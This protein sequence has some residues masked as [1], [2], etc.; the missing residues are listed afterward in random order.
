MLRYRRVGELVG[1]DTSDASLL[2]PADRPLSY[3]RVEAEGSPAGSVALDRALLEA[4]SSEFRLR[5]PLAVERSRDRRRIDEALASLGAPSA[6]PVLDCRDTEAGQELDVAWLD[7]LQLEAVAQS[8]GWGFQRRPGGGAVGGLRIRPLYGLAAGGEQPSRDWQYWNSHWDFEQPP[9]GRAEWWRVRPNES[10]ARP[11]WF[12]SKLRPRR[13]GLGPQARGTFAACMHPAMLRRLGDPIFVVI[14]HPFRGGWLPV[15]VLPDEFSGK[16]G[17]P[18]GGEELWADTLFL[19]RTARDGLGIADGE[20]CLVYPWLRPRRKTWGRAI[21]QRLVGARTIAAHPHAPARADLDKPICRLEPS[22]LEAIG[23]RPGDS[24]TIEHVVPANPERPGYRWRPVRVRS[25]VLPIDAAERDERASWEAP[26][27]RDRGSA[28]AERT[29]AVE[30]QGYVDCADSLGLYPPFPSIYLNYYTRRQGLEG[31]GLCQ[32]VEVR[33]GMPGR[34]AS[35]ASEF[36]W[37]AI[38]ALLGAAIVFL[39]TTSLQIAAA[40]ALTVAMGALLLFRAI[41]AIR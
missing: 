21:S 25:R 16:T 35:E 2:L 3:L 14:R 36:S 27:L 18:E 30:L 33:V 6:Y 31:V 8:T 29:D 40:V 28:G 9:A 37:L 4:R 11:R 13:L 10:R 20:F 5:T 12:L 1:G 22:A 15:R 23:G 26:Q 41:R 24:V 38:I 19:D 32:P 7:G 17:G 34:L 39:P